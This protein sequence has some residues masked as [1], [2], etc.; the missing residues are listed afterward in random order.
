MGLV[1]ACT[2]RFLIWGAP[3]TLSED[4]TLTVSEEEWINHSLRWMWYERFLYGGNI[5]PLNLYIGVNLYPLLMMTHWLYLLFVYYESLSR[6]GRVYHSL[7]W[8]WY[9]RFT[10]GGDIAPLN[11]YIGVYLYPLLMMTHWLSFSSFF[12]YESLSREGWVNH[13]EFI[14]VNVIWR[15]DK[16]GVTLHPSICT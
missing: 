8:M 9:E 12:G 11:L 10:N 2:P 14:T 16:M 15:I 6:E 13:S 7:W 4:N 1:C 3:L 5:A